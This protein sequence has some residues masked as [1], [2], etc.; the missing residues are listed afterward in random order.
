MPDYDA[1]YRILGLQ[2]GASLEEIDESWKLLVNAWHP[3][4]FALNLREP[5]YPVKAG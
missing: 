3:D 2:P 1:L 5:P 4:K